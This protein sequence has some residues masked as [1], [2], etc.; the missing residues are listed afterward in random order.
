[1]HLNH[2][3]TTLIQSVEKLCFMERVPGIE[4]LVDHCFRALTLV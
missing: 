2:P 3:E 4:N 1:M